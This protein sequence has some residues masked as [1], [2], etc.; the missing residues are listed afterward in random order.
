MGQLSKV[1]SLIVLKCSYLVRIGRPEILWSVNKLARSITKRTKACDKRLSRLISCIHHTCEKSIVMWETLPNNADFFDCFKTPILQ[2][3]SRIQNLHQVEH[4][5][6]WEVI[7]LCQSVGCVRIKL[8]FRIR[9]QQN[10]KS[11][12]WTQD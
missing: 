8:Q 5:A 7:R 3:I 9:V 11:S 12:L 1:C 10:Q 6:F 4:C 2:E